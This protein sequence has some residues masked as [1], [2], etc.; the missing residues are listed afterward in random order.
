MTDMPKRQ[1]LN[2]MASRVGPF[3]DSAGVRAWLGIT[4]VD[5]DER[6]SH[7]TILACTTADGQQIFPTWQFG[8]DGTLLPGLRDVL[9]TLAGGT[10]T[11]G[12][13][14]CG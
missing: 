1:P 11:N 7:H 3:Y 12:H 9:E 6:R 8:A 13:G 14:R 10:T 5:L 4:S 2:R